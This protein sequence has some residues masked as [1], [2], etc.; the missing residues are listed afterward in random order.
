V[1]AQVL[2]T[3]PPACRPLASARSRL[4][5]SLVD[6]LSR[7][8]VIPNADTIARPTRRGPR[9]PRRSGRAG[10]ARR[11]R[12]RKEE[13]FLL[14]AGGCS[15]PCTPPPR[16]ASPEGRRARCARAPGSLREPAQTKKG[17]LRI[18]APESSL[19]TTATAPHNDLTIASH[20]PNLNHA[21]ARPL[22][23][24]YLPRND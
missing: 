15:P 11:G 14:E 6:T 2:P 18:A 16:L 3:P 22:S 17:Q 8:P 7:I 5:S 23:V 24:L 13:G 12:S 4:G 10:L 21:P 9:P 19:T 20:P 1:P